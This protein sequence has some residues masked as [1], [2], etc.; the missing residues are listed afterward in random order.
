MHRLH[1]VQNE[2]TYKGGFNG[3]LF[4]LWGSGAPLLEAM[5]TS[6]S[7]FGI[8]LANI[9]SEELSKSPSDQ[10]IVVQSGNWMY[11][12]RIE[13]VEL[14]L[15]NFTGEGLRLLPKLLNANDEWMKKMGVPVV[16]SFHQ[17]S[18]AGHLTVE[19]LTSQ[20]VLEPLPHLRLGDGQDFRAAGQILHWSDSVQGWQ[21]DLV[22]DHSQVVP[23]GLFLLY[24]GM[25]KEWK[26]DYNSLVNS[27]QERLDILLSRL[28][29]CLE[30]R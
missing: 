10:S 15:S 26:L 27:L 24:S 5:Y 18:Y 2:V 20:E 23:D 13:R 14:T 19:E 21:G 6:L 22:V 25:A 28:G 12:W 4:Q 1:V 3:P 16:Y 17:F 9:R 29:L 30:G 11:R 7:P 8:S